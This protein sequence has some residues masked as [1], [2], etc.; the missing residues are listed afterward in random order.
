VRERK[1]LLIEKPL[2]MSA[3][4][5]FRLRDLVEASGL[6]CLMAQTVRLSGVVAAVR[7]ILPEIG[8]PSEIALGKTFEP[9][10]LGW[11]D[12]PEK[13]GGGN[14]LHTGVH[15]FDLLRYLTGG[16]VREVA[17]ITERVTTKLTEDTFVASMSI[18]PGG[19][20]TGSSRALLASVYG[21]RA[22]ESRSGEIRVIGPRGQIVADLIH[23]KLATIR[24]WTWTQR[25]DPPDVPTVRAILQLF[26]P[27]AEGRAE[28]PIT[29]RDGAAAVAIAD[30]C[31]R[32]AESGRRVAVRTE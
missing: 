4:D 25:P 7:E 6:P 1:P 14:I 23:R 5:A 2:A 15:M 24:E 31:Y 17:C 32:A 3:G 20:G 26:A 10:R 8:E 13:A 27:V 21:S 11:L 12:D 19:E 30:A 9:T 22:T 16:E 28:P 29:A 18:R